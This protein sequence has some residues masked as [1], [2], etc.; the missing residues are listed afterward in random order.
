MVVFDTEQRAREFVGRIV[1]QMVDADFPVE[2]T[3]KAD[4]RRD[5]L[6]VEHFSWSEQYYFSNLAAILVGGWSSKAA[7]VKLTEILLKGEDSGPQTLG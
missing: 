1:K 3:H 2:M 6:P 5:H 4:H 7:L